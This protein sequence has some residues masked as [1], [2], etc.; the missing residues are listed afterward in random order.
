MAQSLSK[1]LVHLVFSTKGR[2]ETLTPEIRAELFPYFTGI[3]RN[4][5]CTTLRIGGVE[6]HV[7]LLFAISRTLSIAQVAEK[8]KTSST[9]WIKGKWQIDFA[10]QLGYGAFS[11]SMG[12]A[13]RVVAYI[14]NQEAHHRT[15]SFQDEFLELLREA[16]IDYDEQFLWD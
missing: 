16:G 10:W 12:D 8:V 3:L 15:T 6:D 5:G 11:V 9:K 14:K 1:V 13:D 2:M 4:V 7:H